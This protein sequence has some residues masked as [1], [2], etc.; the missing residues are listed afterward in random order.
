MLMRGSSA[1]ENEPLSEGA[2]IP[3]TQNTFMKC[4]SVSIADISKG[5]YKEGRLKQSVFIWLV[6]QLI[7]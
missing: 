6:C 3:G 7:K 5:F 1:R 4:L 2:T